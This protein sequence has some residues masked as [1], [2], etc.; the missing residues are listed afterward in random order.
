MSKPTRSARAHA[1]RRWTA[2]SSAILV[3]GAL[4][5]AALASTSA[6][7]R[8]QAAPV[9]QSL[10][11]ISGS[12]VRGQALTATSGAWSNTPTT[13]AYRWL[14]CDAGGASC[15]EISGA[16][17]SGY[18]V[19]DADVGK[20]L[21]VE[22]TAGNADGSGQ[23]TSAPTAVVTT[24]AAP[25]S[26]A[27]PT[28]SGSPVEGQTLTATSG[29]WSGTAPI[30]FAYQWVRCGANGGAADGSNCAFISGATGSA[31]KLVGSDVGARMR[32]R[33]T[34]TNAVGQQ[35][36]ASNATATVQ[37]TSSTGAP[38]STKEPTISG[39]TIQG[40]T[41]TANGG[42]WAGAAPITYAY[43]WVRC[44]ADGGRP[45]GS[46]C[47]A[48][49]GA[50]TTRYVLTAA[51]VGQRLRIRVTARNASGSVTVASNP[52]GQIASSGPALPPGAVKLPN[53]K[54]SIPVT[55]VSLPARLIID[56]VAFTPNPVR[57]RQTTLTLRVHVVDTRGYV[58][59]DALVFGRSTPV[60]TSAAGEQRTASDGWA[61]LSM[62]PRASFPLQN[63]HNVQ[64]FVRARKQGDNLLAGISTRRLVQVRT[65][66]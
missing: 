47:P 4:A 66:R 30:S 17:G 10:P 52:T 9:N 48:I 36:V 14:R 6:Q 7:A 41:L 8:A 26:I 3:A 40:Q 61:T 59:R 15:T 11:T 24:S 5:V 44:G 1:A 28:I 43:Q 65:A 39:T 56:S 54:Y 22:V 27:D 23:A 32:V 34:A 25:V 18:T 13:F 49:G 16:T 12:A 53:G 29:G 38:R 64:F 46:N 62:T 45:D 60:L 2:L 57:T 33:V 35:T 20:T 31:Y 37:A 55:S 42:S 51:D 19:A 21:R 58:V 63:G 50:T